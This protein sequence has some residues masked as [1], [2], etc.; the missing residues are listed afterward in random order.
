M[1][2]ADILR[3]LIEKTKQKPLPMKWG[4]RAK[5]EER[6]N[7][8]D[9]SYGPRT[10]VTRQ[11][12]YRFGPGISKLVVRLLPNKV[13]LTTDDPKLPDFQCQLLEICDNER[14][15]LDLGAAIRVRMEGDMRTLMTDIEKVSPSLEP[16]VKRGIPR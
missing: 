12:E 15:R 4:F 11:A 8:D 7:T 2:N 5:V 3:F 10:V 14:L 1:N 13:V 6:N 16:E 9:P